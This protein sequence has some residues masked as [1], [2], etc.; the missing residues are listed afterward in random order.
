MEGRCEIDIHMSEGG[1]EGERERHTV[2]GGGL[3]D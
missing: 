3:V 2:G 1:G